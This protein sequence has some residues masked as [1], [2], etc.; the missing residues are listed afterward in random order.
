MINY[1]LNQLNGEN[2]KLAIN[3][4]NNYPLNNNNSKKPCETDDR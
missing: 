1:I 3:T 4:F 2:L